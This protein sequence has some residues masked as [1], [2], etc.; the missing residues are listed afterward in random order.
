MDEAF[1]N[2]VRE[3]RKYNK[4]CMYL[5]WWIYQTEGLKISRI[6]KQG[7]PFMGVEVSLEAMEERTIMMMEVLDAVVAVLPCRMLALH[8]AYPMQ[9]ISIVNPHILF[10]LP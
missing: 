6:N 7:D 3:I 1:T 2:L 8:R 5:C 4:V 9:F 10:H